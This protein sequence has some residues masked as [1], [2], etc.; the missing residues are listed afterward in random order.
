[1][2]VVLIFAVCFIGRKGEA[3]VNF[4]DT[5]YLSRTALKHITPAMIDTSGLSIDADLQSFIAATARK[6]RVNFGAVAVMDAYN[7]D[8]LALYGKDQSGE[9][10]SIPL[11]AYLAASIFKIVTASAAIDRGMT[12]LS[13]VTYRGSPYTLYKGQLEAR[14]DRWT[15]Q[16][17]LAQA[18]AKSNNVVFGKIGTHY[19]G[20]HP[21]LLEA[22]RLGFWKPVMRECWSEPSAVFIPESEYNIAEMACGFNHETRMSPVHAAQIISAVVN[23][24]RMVTPRLLR[25]MGVES[26]RVMSDAK[27]ESLRFMMAETLKTGTYANGF[28]ACKYDRVMKDLDLGA[29]SGSID[30]R[31]PEGRLNWFVGYAEHPER[32]A[33]T[34]AC[35]FLR[36][37]YYLIKADDMARMIIKEYFTEHGLVAI[38]SRRGD[39]PRFN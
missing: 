16:I 3:D 6:Y 35:L 10:C 22:M 18:F 19:L 31:Y 32:G 21:I 4:G 25:V 1:V 9:D 36:D 5:R 14:D 23:G 38:K 34:I 8:I 26:M 33:I 11:D 15:Q 37:A 2:I 29:K 27:A 7:G 12:P 28:K 17:T 39:S 24:G 20:E 30:S 13:P